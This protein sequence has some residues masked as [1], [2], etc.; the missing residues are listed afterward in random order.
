MKIHNTN[1]TLMNYPALKKWGGGGHTRFSINHSFCQNCRTIYSF[2]E[3]VNYY[4][5]PKL[6]QRNQNRVRQYR[7]M[8]RACC[9]NCG[10][11]FLPSLMTADGAQKNEVQFLCR[12]QTIDAVEEYF[13]RKNIGVLTK[14]KNNI[15]KSAL[16]A[17]GNDVFVKGLDENQTLIANTIQYAPFNLIMN[18]VNGTNIE[19]YDLLFDE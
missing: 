9:N 14:N 7:K 10:V 17:I 19:K 6:D 12:V 8:T 4:M 1:I 11:Y 16:K 2:K 18:L 5:N 15:Q 13:S 3:I